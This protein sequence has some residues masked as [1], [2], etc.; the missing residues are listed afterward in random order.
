MGIA[1]IVPAHTF[2][3]SRDDAVY[4]RKDM[5]EVC[6]RTSQIR[7]AGIPAPLICDV[8]G[9]TSSMSLRQYTA[10]SLEKLKVCAG[11]ISAIPIE[12]EALL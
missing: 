1:E 7:G 3:F 12:Q 10:S 5:D 4:W 9:H 2:N 11:T 6:P 8:L